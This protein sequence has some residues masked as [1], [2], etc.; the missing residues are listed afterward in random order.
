[1]RLE[2]VI[3]AALLAGAC[4]QPQ[5]IMDRRNT[6]EA[7]WKKDD[8]ACMQEA[9]A[10]GGGVVNQY[11]RYTREPNPGMYQKCMEARGYNRVK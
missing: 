5:I 8:F 1:M 3:V 6:T 2:L 10:S 4:G 11:G 7:E 9:Y